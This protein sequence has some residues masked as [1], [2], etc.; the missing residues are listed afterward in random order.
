MGTGTFVV[1]RPNV[2]AYEGNKNTTFVRR[3]VGGI[4]MKIPNSEAP[5]FGI[6]RTFKNPVDF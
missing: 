4:L 2:A 5:E 1:F 6:F 3:D